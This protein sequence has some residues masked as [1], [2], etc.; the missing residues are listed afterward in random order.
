MEDGVGNV[1]VGRLSITLPTFDRL[2]YGHFDIIRHIVA[3][4]DILGMSSVNFSLGNL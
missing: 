3:F 2:I 1:N 4:E